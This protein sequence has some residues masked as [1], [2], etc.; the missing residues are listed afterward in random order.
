MQLEKVS[1]KL[2]GVIFDE[3]F[4]SCFHLQRIVVLHARLAAAFDQKKRQIAGI[5][6]WFYESGEMVT[7][8]GARQ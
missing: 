2:S 1:T 4:L 7:G 8:F 6:R 3:E 5:I